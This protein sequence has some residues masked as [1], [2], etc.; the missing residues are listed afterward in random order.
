MFGVYGVGMLSVTGLMEN[1]AE[2]WIQEMQ[3]ALERD[4]TQVLKLCSF[5]LC[6]KVSRFY[7]ICIINVCVIN[8]TIDLVTINGCVINICIM[9]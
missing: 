4:Y 6:V 7:N 8:Y 9:L 5:A 3:I 2:R 1:L